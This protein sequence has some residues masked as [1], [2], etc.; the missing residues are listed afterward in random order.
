[1][2]YFSQE[3]LSFIESSQS[4]IALHNSKLTEESVSTKHES[5]SKIQKYWPGLYDPLS[6]KI[7]GFPNLHFISSL[8]Q[9]VS[10]KDEPENDQGDDDH[11]Q[12]I[13]PTSPK[14]L[15]PYQRS[16]SFVYPSVTKI[17]LHR[18][19]PPTPTTKS[20][21]KSNPKLSTK[22]SEDFL[23]E[24]ELSSSATDILKKPAPESLFI[25]DDVIVHSSPEKKLLSTL[26]CPP[27]VYNS[28]DSIY[29]DHVSRF[30]SRAS[31][32]YNSQSK[33][34]KRPISM[35]FTEQ[36]G[37]DEDDKLIDI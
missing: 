10:D 22:T 15:F 1:V 37:S 26:S 16:R 8:I 17:Q 24:E 30:R 33:I 25:E 12:I 29:R 23:I 34:L 7:D 14:S 32:N 13:E 27:T 4:N 19:L 18:L 28:N 21:S 36:D 20:L 5:L 31:S 3:L 2:R 11:D 9:D 35:N 6:T